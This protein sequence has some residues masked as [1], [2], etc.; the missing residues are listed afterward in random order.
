MKTCIAISGGFRVGK[1]TLANSLSLSLNLGTIAHYAFADK[2][3]ECA[4]RLYPDMASQVYAEDKTPEARAFIKKVGQ[5]YIDHLGEDVWTNYVLNKAA[6]LDILIISDVRWLSECQ[7]IERAF[8]KVIYIWL[9]DYDNTF[10]GQD[11]IYN[12]PSTLKFP[13]RPSPQSILE[14]LSWVY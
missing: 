9:G 7:A 13:A 12:N 10:C 5:F 6:N 11:Y 14:A 2:I 1:T 3:K 8:D 4:A